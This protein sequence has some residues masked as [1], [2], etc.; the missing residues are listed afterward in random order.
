MKNREKAL[1]EGDIPAVD[2]GVDVAMNLPR[3]Q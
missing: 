1:L 3:F 2:Q